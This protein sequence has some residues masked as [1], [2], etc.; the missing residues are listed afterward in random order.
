MP[1]SGSTSGRGFGSEAHDTAQCAID[2]CRVCAVPHGSDRSVRSHTARWRAVSRSLATSPPAG[3]RR[4]RLSAAEARRVALAA[5]GFAEPPLT[6]RRRHARAAQPRP[7]PRRPDPDRLGQR[8]AARALPADV[9][10]AGGVRHRAAGQVVA[11]RAAAAVRVL[12][13]R[14][15][16]DPGRAAPAPALADAARARRRVGRDAPD[17]D[18]AA[19]ARGRRAGGLARARSA[20]RLPAGRARRAARAQGTVVGLVGRQARAGVPVLERGDHERA[21]AALRADLRHARARD[22]G[23]RSWRSRRRRR[24][25]PA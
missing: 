24:C 20:D 18:R 1:I 7:R 22:P 13:P 16:A 19:G 23:R 11:L 14:G 4:E 6:A 21:A 10:P 5:Q 25:R 12:G 15:V 3:R 8:A 17:R 9:Q 2:R